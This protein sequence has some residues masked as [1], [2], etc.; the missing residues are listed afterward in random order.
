MAMQCAY[1]PD[2]EPVGAC[3]ECG[4]LICAGC[5]TAVKGKFYCPPCADKVFVR[6]SEEAVKSADAAS[7]AAVAAGSAGAVQQPISI[8]V[9]AGTVSPTGTEAAIVNNSGQGS[10]AAL[11]DQLRGWSWGAFV[12]TWIWGIF[13]STW[14]AFLAFVPFLGIIWAFVLGARG[15]AWAWQN[16]NW[17][18]AERFKKTQRTWDKWGK[19]LF[20][21]GIAAMVLYFVIAAIL[22]A[23]GYAH[24]G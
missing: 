21:I 24:W 4:R 3:V 9:N 22:V 11:P 17:D 13:N 18:S 14:I 19:V 10:K 7:P 1:H 16:K 20:I 23:T 8:T 6:R 12:L 5:K 2:R 15:R